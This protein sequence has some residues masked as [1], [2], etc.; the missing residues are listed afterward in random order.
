MKK[1]VG[2]GPN[3]GVLDFMFSCF[4]IFNA[5]LLRSIGILTGFKNSVDSYLLCRFRLF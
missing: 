5:M 3:G 2:R 4:L 1:G